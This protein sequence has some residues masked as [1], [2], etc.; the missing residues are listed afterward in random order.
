MFHNLE[1]RKK[2]F[3]NQGK[4]KQQKCDYVLSSFLTPTGAYIPNNIDTTVGPCKDFYQFACG[5][6]IKENP[7]PKSSTGSKGFAKTDLASFVTKETVRG[8]I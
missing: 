2:G 5:R 8:K 4:F 1:A 7:I 3:K 6:W